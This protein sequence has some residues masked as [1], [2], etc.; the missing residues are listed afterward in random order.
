MHA[1]R[2]SSLAVVRERDGAAM[3]REYRPYARPCSSSARW[4]RKAPGFPQ[5]ALLCALGVASLS[6]ELTIPW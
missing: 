1:V 2:Q 4:N 5:N 6:C 3:H